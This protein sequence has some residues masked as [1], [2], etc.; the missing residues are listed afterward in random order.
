MIVA[1]TTLDFR[2]GYGT[3]G[4]PAVP[5]V[6]LADSAEQ[7]SLHANPAAT[8]YGDLSKVLEGI[9]EAWSVRASVGR[10]LTW[11]Q[12]LAE[13]AAAAIARTSTS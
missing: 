7:L 4:D 3:F 13:H 12:K 6:H 1:G 9:A 2:L 10:Y 11:A 5:V 8:A